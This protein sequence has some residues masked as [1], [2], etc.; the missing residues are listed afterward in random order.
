MY[1]ISNSP[2]YLAEGDEMISEHHSQQSW[3]T[4]GVDVVGGETAVT[5]QIWSQRKSARVV[6]T[7][8]FKRTA[9]VLILF[10]SF[11]LGVR[12]QFPSKIIDVSLDV[13][14]CVFSLE[15]ALSAVFYQESLVGWLAFDLTIIVGSWLTGDRSALV[16]R[17]FRLLRTFRKAT[18]IPALRCVVKSILRALPRMAATVGLLLPTSL[19]IFSIWLTNLYPEEFSRLDTSLLTLFQI[20]TGGASWADVLQDIEESRAWIPLSTFVLVA[21]FIFASLIVAIMSHSVSTVNDNERIWKSPGSTDMITSGGT[22]LE[23]LDKKIADLTSTVEHLLQ[24][25][26]QLLKA[27]SKRDSSPVPSIES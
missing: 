15:L 14:L 2:F 26:N 20:M 23:K 13:L 7:P 21:Q 11:L 9:L 25:Q 5:F 4:E 8:I 22:E 1:T 27:L 17:S 16:L 10:C 24:G 18:G 3:E 6:N 19:L 12:T